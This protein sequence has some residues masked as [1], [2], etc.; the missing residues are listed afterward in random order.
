MSSWVSS[1]LLLVL[2]LQAFLVI[3][4]SWQIRCRR[5]ERLKWHKSPMGGWPTA[6][7]VLCLR[8]A[9]ERLPE[10]LES[11]AKQEYLGD[12]RL[13]IVVD[14]VKDPSWK[15]VNEFIALQ[16]QNARSN[17]A[18]KEVRLQVLR[19]RPLM[20]SLKCASLLQAFDSLDSD[21][22]VIAIVDA[23]AVV[24]HKWLS[25]LVLSCCQPGVG[26]V[27]GNRWFIPDQF[28]LMSWSRSVWNAGAL[29]L[30]TL[31][32]IPWGGSLAVR[33]EVVEAGEWKKLLGSGLCEDTGLLEPLRKLDLRFVFRPELLVVNRE[34]STNLFSLT[35]WIGRQLLTARLHHSAWP[36]VALHG[37]STFLLLLAAIFHNEWQ[38]VLI[39][40]LGCL[41]LLVW[42]EIIA[43][44]R[45]PLSVWKWAIALFP[46]QIINGVATIHAFFARKVEWSGVIYKVAL[47]PRGVMLMDSSE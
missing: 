1:A 19:E 31:L 39:Y 22:A 42:I 26:A 9:D 21:S 7:I 34:T 4:F 44:Q 3:L 35:K 43:M 17:V 11:I 46:G 41:G 18:W 28:T 29:V 40:E 14:S 30:M 33:R 12:W 45:P 24:S 23:D 36:L 38:A 10:M 6:E 20:G 2:A 13:Q 37:F 15:I 25:Q 5:L 16:F 32:A 8:G 47:K 27:S